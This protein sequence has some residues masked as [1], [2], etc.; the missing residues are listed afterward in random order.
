MATILMVDDDADLVAAVKMMLE[1]HGHQVHSAPNGEQGLRR[2][3]E[4]NPDL[5]ILDIMMDRYTEGF[6]FSQLL[7]NP[8]DDSRYAGYR[9]VP[10]LVLSSIHRTTSHRFTPREGSLPVDAFLDKSV[11]PDVLLR[12]IEGLVSKKESARI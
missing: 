1:A 8:D 9:S 10:I 6:R 11:S 5:I 2:V 7:R 3:A 4:T 12:T